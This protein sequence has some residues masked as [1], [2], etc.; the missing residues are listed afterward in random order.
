MGLGRRCSGTQATRGP[1]QLPLE[2]G[3]RRELREFPGGL[4]V[5]IRRFHCRG[6]GSIPGRGTEIK[7]YIKRD[8]SL[9]M[10]I[11]CAYCRADRH[12]SCVE[13]SVWRQGRGYW[14]LRREF[15]DQGSTAKEKMLLATRARDAVEP[16]GPE[17]AIL[18]GRSP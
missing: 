10:R 11:A 5:R 3:S 14:P 1:P 8:L 2:T 4:V 18:P 16:L 6:P 9:G 7:K 13:G 15:G 17:M 12:F